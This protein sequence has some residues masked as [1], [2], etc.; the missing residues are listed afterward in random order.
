MFFVR[1]LWWFAVVG[2]IW[3][4]VSVLSLVVGLFLVVCF[5]FVG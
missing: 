4:V 2:L 5:V 1:V 3:V